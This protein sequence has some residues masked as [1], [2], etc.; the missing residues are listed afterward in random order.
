MDSID[1]IE[2]FKDSKIK[3]TLKCRSG[4]IEKSSKEETKQEAT[5]LEKDFLLLLFI[6]IW[7]TWPVESGL[8]WAFMLI[9]TGRIG[10]GKW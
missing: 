2:I 9:T 6:Q 8:V 5:I 4:H 3:C 7:S 10:W 1:C